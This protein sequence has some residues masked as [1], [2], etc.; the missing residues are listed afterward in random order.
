MPKFDVAKADLERLVG[1]SFTVEQWE[2]LFLYAKC[3]L[4]DVWE[5]NGK[6][7]F[8]ADAKDTNRPDLWSAEGIARQVKWA[9]GMKKGLPKYEVKKSD[10]VVYVDEKL[11][12]IRPYGV[13]AVVE[14]VNLDDE[15]LKQLI[16]LQEKIALT[17]GRKRREVAIGTF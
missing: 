2:D 17:F 7:Y 15:A 4:D 1:K 11:K 16:Q 13:Y 14:D 9:L 10:V 8:K 6:I 5:E 12:D 3:E